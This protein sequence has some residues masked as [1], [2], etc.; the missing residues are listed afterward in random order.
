[1]SKLGFS[2]EEQAE[3]LISGVQRILFFEKYVVLIT[4]KDLIVLDKNRNKL[5]EFD[6]MRDLILNE[7]QSAL[8]SEDIKNRTITSQ[9]LISADIVKLNDRV[10]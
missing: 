7:E 6:Y 1:M 10:Y 4:G 3:E 8:N 2:N 5:I 9:R